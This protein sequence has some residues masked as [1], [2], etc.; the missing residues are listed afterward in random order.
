MPAMFGH[1]HAL[2]PSVGIF[3]D[4]PLLGT[5]GRSKSSGRL[6]TARHGIVGFVLS[7][8][9]RCTAAGI[10]HIDLELSFRIR[11]KNNPVPIRGPVRAAGG[12]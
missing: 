8:A 7:H 3:P 11:I 10:H 12:S 9:L 4:L 2:P 6:L 1:F 5:I